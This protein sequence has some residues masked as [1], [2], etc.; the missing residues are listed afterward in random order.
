MIETALNAILN[1]MVDLLALIPVPEWAQ[2]GVGGF[3]PYV[4]WGLWFVNADAG[5]SIILAAFTTRFLIRRLP[6]IG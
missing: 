2:G 1:T 4:E 3:H 5:A 6:F